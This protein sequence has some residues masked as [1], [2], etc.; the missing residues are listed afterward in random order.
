LMNLRRIEYEMDAMTILKAVVQNP[1]FTLAE[2]L[3]NFMQGWKD[4][5]GEV[6]VRWVDELP[7]DEKLKAIAALKELAGD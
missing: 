3:A 6:I 5:A 4:G 7:H 2:N 1:H